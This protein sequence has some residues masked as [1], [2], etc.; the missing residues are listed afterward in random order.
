VPE[1]ALGDFRTR[2]RDIYGRAPHPLAILAYDGLL[3]AA[4]AAEDPTTAIQ[5]I[6]ET[7]GFQGEAGIFRLLPDGRTQHALAIFELTAGGP[8]V[9]DPAP[10]RFV[11]EPS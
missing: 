9:V 2:F 10:L 6:T 3:V 4:D 5:R 1:Q 8:V 7:R 11:D